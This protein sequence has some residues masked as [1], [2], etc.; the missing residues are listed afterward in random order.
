MSMPG[1]TAEVALSK[2]HGH[3]QLAGAFNQADGTIRA[4]SGLALF[5]PLS[6]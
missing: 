3:Y 2:T 6:T 1:F 5:N 4:Q